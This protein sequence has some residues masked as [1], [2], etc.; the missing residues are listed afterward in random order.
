ME[1]S[2]TQPTVHLYCGRCIGG[3]TSPQMLARFSADGCHP[4]PDTYL[5]ME[6][7]VLKAIGEELK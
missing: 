5:I 6:E 2:Y 4:N 1:K 3:Q 7:L